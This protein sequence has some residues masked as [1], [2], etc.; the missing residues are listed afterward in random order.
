MAPDAARRARTFWRGCFGALAGLLLLLFAARVSAAPPP[1]AVLLLFPG[2]PSEPFLAELQQKRWDGLRAAAGL[3]LMNAAVPGAPDER[4]PAYGALL[5]GRRMPAPPGSAGEPRDLFESLREEGREARVVH[6][7]G[8]P[9]VTGLQDQLLLRIPKSATVPPDARPEALARAARAHLDEAQLVT[10]L[11]PGGEPTAALEVTE[12]V[13]GVLDPSRDLVLL[14]S[15]DPGLASWNGWQG[16]SPVLMLGRGAEGRLLTSGTTRTAGL[17]ANTDLAPTLLEHLG[18]PVPAAVEGHAVRTGPSGGAAELLRSA[19][20][21]RATR[22]A[23]TPGLLGWGAFLL[24]TFGLSGWCAFRRRPGPFAACRLVLAWGAAFPAGM[25]LAASLDYPSAWAL[26][27]GIVAVSLLVTLPAATLRHRIPPLLVVFT[28]TLLVL[29][30]DLFTGGRLL[31]RNLMSDYANIGARYYGIGNEYLGLVAGVA[32]IVPFWWACRRD[33]ARVSPAGWAVVAPLWL[34]VLAAVAAPGFGADFGGALSFAATAVLAFFLGS[35]RGLKPRNLLV[36]AGV[37]AA[38]AAVVVLWDLSR[39]PDLRTHVGDLFAGAL[40]GELGPLRE[41]VR[42][43][44]ELNLTMALSPFFLGSLAAVTPLLWLWYSKHGREAWAVLSE[45]P[46]L[47]AAVVS[48]ALGGVITL[49]LNDTGV[50][51]WA[52]ATGCALYLW[53]D[54]LLAARQDGSTA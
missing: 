15:P 46:L 13:W 16:L 3:A 54:T 10:V 48:S 47:R 45:R 12:R 30:G 25:L 49:L 20:N 35:G 40:R 41:M 37:A 9:L 5:R 32:L 53:M 28:L 14:A 6:L 36:A 31:A 39:P 51:A 29:L 2:T 1:R 4:L 24:V 42:R 52:L 38:A 43:K 27:L 50:I 19:A 33:C 17:L 7:A 23:I 21:A 26:M 34:V 8:E 11:L 44:V 22:T 18:V